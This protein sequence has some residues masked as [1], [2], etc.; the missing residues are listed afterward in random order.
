MEAH[1]KNITIGLKWLEIET[2]TLYQS[3]D[4]GL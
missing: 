1:P 4:Q 3:S 2:K